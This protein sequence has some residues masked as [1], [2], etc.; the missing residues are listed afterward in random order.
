MEFPLRYGTLLP[1][2]FCVMSLSES[3]IAPE[4]PL[5]DCRALLSTS[6]GPQNVLMDS[7]PLVN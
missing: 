5:R 7:H 2:M 6:A 1:V 3:P 4:N